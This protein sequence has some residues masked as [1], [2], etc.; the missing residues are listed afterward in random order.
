MPTTLPPDLLC[1]PESRANQRSRGVVGP[2]AGSSTY[3]LAFILGMTGA[4]WAE[5]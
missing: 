2:A 1:G 4:I 3:T 5:G